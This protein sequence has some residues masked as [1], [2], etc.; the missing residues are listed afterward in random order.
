[1]AGAA[2]PMYNITACHI[3]LRANICHGLSAGR[4]RIC[5][6]TQGIFGFSLPSLCHSA[7]VR[8][9]L[10]VYVRIDGNCVL[11]LNIC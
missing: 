5:V 6:Q 11:K 4:Q 2:A 7:H 1:M 3:D 9:C 8:V 10:Q